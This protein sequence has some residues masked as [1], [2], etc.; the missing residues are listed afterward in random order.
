M[1]FTQIS[2]RKGKSLDYRRELMEEIYLAMR[3]SISIPENDRFAT[4]TELEDGNFNN[5]GDYLGISRSD[6]I[7]FIQITLNSGRTTDK[8][9]ALYAKVA[10]RL[11]ANLNIRPED[12]VISL[13]EVEME[14]WSLGNGEA[15]YA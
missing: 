15:Q 14:D 6:D 7:V 5:S 10:E 11:H 8:K 4:I 1:P 13:L 12:V 3:E 9:K 2:L